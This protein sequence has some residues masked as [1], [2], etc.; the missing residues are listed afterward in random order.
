MEQLG[1]EAK[2]KRRHSKAI[3]LRLL[4]EHDEIVREAAENAGLSVSGWI[5]ERVLRYA[6]EE[7]GIQPGRSEAEAF[8]PSATRH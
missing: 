6:R 3:H 5:R 2:K 4:P 1:M 7:L 8:V